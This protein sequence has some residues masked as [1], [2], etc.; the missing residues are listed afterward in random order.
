MKSISLFLVVAC[1]LT[2]VGCRSSRGPYAA[3]RADGGSVPE[4]GE[5]LYLTRSLQKVLVVESGRAYRTPRNRM[6]VEL[7]FR[8]TQP[9]PL[10]LQIRTTFLT[11]D[12]S[13]TGRT[14]FTNFLMAAHETKSFRVTSLNDRPD[15]YLIQIRRLSS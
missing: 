9:K 2:V 12:G 11:E 3:T 15:R 8:N 5:I 4:A 10:H 13:E 6:G 14:S 7:T 1:A